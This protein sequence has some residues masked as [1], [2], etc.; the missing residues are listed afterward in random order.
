M[1][2]IITMLLSKTALMGLIALLSSLGLFHLINRCF[3]LP[4]NNIAE[5]IVEEVIKEETGVD[6]NL[7]PDAPD[8]KDIQNK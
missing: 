3:H 8:S 6:I 1:N 4:D 7:T 2:D 5:K